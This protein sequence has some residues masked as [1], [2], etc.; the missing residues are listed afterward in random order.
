L[1]EI[2][3]ERAICEDAIV[4][5]CVPDDDTARLAVLKR[6]ELLDVKPEEAFDRITRLTKKVMQMPMAMVN[7]VDKDRD[8][9]L[10]RQGIDATEGP[11]SNTSF[12]RHAVKQNEPLIVNDVLEDPRFAK[13]P[14]V[15]HKNVR[16]ILACRFARARATI[17]A[18]C[19]HWTRR[20]GA[21]IPSKSRLCRC[22]RA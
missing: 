19:A 1:A 5:H 21:S 22:W 6:Y 11:R 12:C 14:L 7:M 16:F 2:S 10:S 20:R 18:R 15:R 8:W 3:T 13:N 17:S 4:L 9:V